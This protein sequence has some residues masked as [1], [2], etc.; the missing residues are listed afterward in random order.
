MAGAGTFPAEKDSSLT[1]HDAPYHQGSAPQNEEDLPST[2]PDGG[3]GWTIVVAILF[4][5]AVTW[6]TT[7]LLSRPNS[8]DI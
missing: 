3:Y 8:T 2:P 4:L 1:F 7:I 6:G 5:N